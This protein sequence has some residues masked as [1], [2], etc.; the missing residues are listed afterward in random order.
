MTAGELF[1]LAE[2]YAT[3]LINIAYGD[4][5]FDGSVEAQ[6][7]WPPDMCRDVV[8]RVRDTQR[9]TVHFIFPNL[10]EDQRQIITRLAVCRWFIARGDESQKQEFA[11]IA[12]SVRGLNLELPEI[13]S[14]ILGKYFLQ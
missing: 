4:F 2:L 12:E 13:Q 10:N 3:D 8:K 7:N 6:A 14:E 1:E 11:A 5:D 9:F